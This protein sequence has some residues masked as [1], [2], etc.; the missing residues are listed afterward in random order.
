M[1]EMQNVGTWACYGEVQ[2]PEQNLNGK[3]GNWFYN[4][5]KRAKRGKGSS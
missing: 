4:N 3:G 2:L 1:G 5:N